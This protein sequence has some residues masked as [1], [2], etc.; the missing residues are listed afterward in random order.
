MALAWGCLGFRES[1]T[2]LRV[3]GVQ[4]LVGLG[5]S[6]LSSALHGARGLMF[7]GRVELVQRE[8][9]KSACPFAVRLHN[10]VAL[11]GGAL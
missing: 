8:I 2:A 1:G 3:W 6:D 5:R 7:A 4:L 11:L 10:S 9:Q